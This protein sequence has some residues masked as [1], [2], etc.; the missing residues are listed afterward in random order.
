[1]HIRQPE[2]P[3]LRAE[4]EFG[5]LEPEQVKDGRLQ[6]VNVDLV[7]RDREPKLIRLTKHK[8]RLDPPTRQKNREAIGIMVAAENGARLA[9]R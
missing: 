9:G 2:I 4:R 5:V 6:V 7:F 8:P 1:M 3:A